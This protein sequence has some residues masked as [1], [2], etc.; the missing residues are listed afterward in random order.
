MCEGMRHQALV[1][2]GL[3]IALGAAVLSLNDPAAARTLGFAYLGTGLARL[4]SMLVDGWR[5][6]SNIISLAL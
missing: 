2:G 3:L 1:L 5:E 6:T 4:I